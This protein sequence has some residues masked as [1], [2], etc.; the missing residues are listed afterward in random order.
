MVVTTITPPECAA[1]Q[2]CDTAKIV[3]DPV[4]TWQAYVTMIGTAM[5]AAGSVMSRRP[6]RHMD[7]VQLD[8]APR[9]HT[10]D[11]PDGASL[12]GRRPRTTGISGHSRPI[13]SALLVTLSPVHGS[14]IGST[15]TGL[16]AY[17][18]NGV[19]DYIAARSSLDLGPAPLR[20]Q[21][22]TCGS[23]A[24][25]RP[26]GGRQPTYRRL[27]G[28]LIRIQMPGTP[29]IPVFNHGRPPTSIPPR[30]AY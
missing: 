1:N 15:A 25:G 22:G 21:D 28:R 8:K 24:S 27:S 11:R 18:G 3:L 29:D 7:L 19:D 23:T 30:R 17:Q 16:V 14:P 10:V 4:Q 26:T 12:H 9:R 6:R 13:E 5:A 20:C 2:Q